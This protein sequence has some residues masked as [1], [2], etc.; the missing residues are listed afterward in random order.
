MGLTVHGQSHV[1]LRH[2][3]SGHDGLAGVRPSVV[4]R[5]SFQLQGVAVAEHLEGRREKECQR[6][7]KERKPEKTFREPQ[8]TFREPDACCEGGAEVGQKGGC[9]NKK[10]CPV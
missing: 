8:K 7:K 4:L 9:K 5:H 2:S 3:D 6:V 1:P 10:R